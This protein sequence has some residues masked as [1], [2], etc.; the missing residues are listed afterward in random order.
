MKNIVG[1]SFDVLHESVTV[2]PLTFQ[3]AKDHHLERAGKKIA[4]VVFCHA[5]Q[6]PH[7]VL[8]QAYQVKA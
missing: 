2:Q 7:P 1:V 3:G 8:V 4:L 6:M 5:S